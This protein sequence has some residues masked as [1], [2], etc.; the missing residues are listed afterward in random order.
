MKRS[1]KQLMAR[2]KA[3][4]EGAPHWRRGPTGAI[5]VTPREERRRKRGVAAMHVSRGSERL[6]RLIRSALV[7]VFEMLAVVLVA[8]LFGRLM[9]ELYKGASVGR[10]VIQAVLGALAFA[11]WL[12][13]TRERYKDET[14]RAIADERNRQLRAD[15]LERRTHPAGQ[16]QRVP[17]V[18]GDRDAGSQ[19]ATIPPVEDITRTDFERSFDQHPDW[20]QPV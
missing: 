7:A 13:F 1:W 14:R 3:R 19:T 10:T 12:V 2:S 18:G 4:A 6:N 11:T 17:G 20:D 9:Y 5:P 15:A 8:T 16:G